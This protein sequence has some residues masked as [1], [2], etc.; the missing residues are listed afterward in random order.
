MAEKQKGKKI[1]VTEDI[2]ESSETIDKSKELKVSD[3]K[4]ESTKPADK[5]KEQKVWYKKTSVVVIGIVAVV[6]VVALAG[7]FV[8]SDS[9]TGIPGLNIIKKE[10]KLPRAL[11]GVLVDSEFANTYPVGLMIENLITVRPQEGLN[12]ASVVYEALAEGGI[13]RF[14]ALYSITEPI[15]SIGP[16]RSARPYYVDWAQEYKALYGHVGGSP[17]SLAKISQDE[18]FDLNQFFN[19][20]YYIRD[21]RFG[22]PHNVFTSSDMLSFALRDKEA[23]AEG[24]FEPWLFKDGLTEA[25]R[26]LET[27]PIVIDYSTFNYKVEYNYDR[28]DNKYERSQAGEPFMSDDNQLAPTNVIVQYVATGLEDASRLTMETVGS[29][30]AMVFRDGSAIQA[31]WRKADKTA[32]TKFYDKVT[33]QEISLNR[34]STWVQVVPTTTIVEY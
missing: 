33:D 26:P 14:L 2:K 17:T 24:D 10:Q 5:P 6:V 7:Y 18:V 22:A 27:Q 25:N 4:K 9:D 13:S 15:K 32:R 11:D 29:G 30:E 20:Q 23:P 31:T 34:G 28:I 12:E 8:F 16:I 21:S 3:D 19:S 1:K